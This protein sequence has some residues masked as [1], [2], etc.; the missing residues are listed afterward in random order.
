MMEGCKGTKIKLHFRRLSN[1]MKTFLLGLL[2]GYFFSELFFICG[3]ISLFFVSEDYFGIF[4][5]L[6][7][8][9]AIIQL[10]TLYRV[11][12]VVNRSYNVLYAKEK[13]SGAVYLI[14]S[15]GFRRSVDGIKV[16][17][18]VYQISDGVRVVVTK[19]GKIIVFSMLGMLIFWRSG[20]IRTTPPDNYWIPLFEAK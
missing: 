14:E 3:W 18:K 8:I 17:G 11:P 13:N 1:V 19:K 5:L 20:G 2:N 6:L 15:G 12:Q 10:I 7:L 16:N 9:G 4:G